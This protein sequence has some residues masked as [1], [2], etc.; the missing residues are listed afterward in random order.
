LGNKTAIFIIRN[1]YF[2]LGLLRKVNQQE[3]AIATKTF[4]KINGDNSM[5]LSLF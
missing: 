1:D 4:I 5:Q 2:T 3:I